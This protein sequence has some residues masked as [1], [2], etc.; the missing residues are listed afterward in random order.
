MENRSKNKFFTWSNEVG[1]LALLSEFPKELGCSDF[2]EENYS[3]IGV[4]PENCEDYGIFSVYS[5]KENRGYKGEIPKYIVVC[6][7]IYEWDVLVFYQIN[8]ILE[9]INK[10]MPLIEYQERIFTKLS[11]AQPL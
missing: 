3:L 5:K 9:F 7:L 8:Q 10:F 11:V 6:S 2:T 1:F 4:Y